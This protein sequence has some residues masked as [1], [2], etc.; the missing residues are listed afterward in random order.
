[1]KRTQDGL[2]LKGTKGN[3]RALAVARDGGIQNADQ[4]GNRSFIHCGVAI[5]Y[6][7]FLAEGG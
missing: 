2:H 4:R 5:L 1:M 3:K 7:F 6:A